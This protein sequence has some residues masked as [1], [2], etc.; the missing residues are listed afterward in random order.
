VTGAEIG[1]RA[2]KKQ[3][4]R[5]LL[6]DTA[7][8]LFAERG[9]ERV[10][11]AEIA[12]R[13]EV[14]EA[15]VYNYFGT[16]EDL[17]YDGMAAFEDALV[18]AVRDRPPGRPVLAAFREFL[19]T[20]PGVLSGVDPTTAA[21]ITT[22]ARVI[23]SSPALRAREQQLLD[24]CTRSLAAVIAGPE[25]DDPDDV[26]PWVVANALVGV[27]G[28]LVRYVRARVLA[29]DPIDATLAEGVRDRAERSLALLARGLDHPAT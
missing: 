18:T 17:V 10:R 12:R 14:A 4:T 7:L 16:K 21:R 24:R 13:A 5:R 25:P 23:A 8:A 22:A 6:A 29:G 26:E 1:L 3:Q 27:H 20:A 28:A 2:R 19:L 11:V 9:F 15:T